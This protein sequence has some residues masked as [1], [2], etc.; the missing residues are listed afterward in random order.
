MN[1]TVDD[2]LEAFAEALKRPAAAGEPGATT[3]ELAKVM[4]KGRE[5]MRDILREEIESGRVEE[6][7]VMRRALGGR[8]QPVDGY[9]LKP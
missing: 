8:M 7:K 3:K 1:A 6:V 2:I 5:R 4:G 9:R